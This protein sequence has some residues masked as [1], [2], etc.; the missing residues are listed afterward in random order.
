MK[1]GCWPT[2]CGE[3]AERYESSEIA[4]TPMSTRAAMPMMCACNLTFIGIEETGPPARD[5]CRTSRRTGT[6][7]RT[8]FRRLISLG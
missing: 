6:P 8:G 2:S 1:S 5:R 3:S 7:G 4:V